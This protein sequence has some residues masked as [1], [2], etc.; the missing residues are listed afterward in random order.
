[1]AEMLYD[2]GSAF[3]NYF[4]IIDLSY[5]MHSLCM[6]TFASKQYALL[7][8]ILI[9][10]FYVCIINYIVLRNNNNAKNK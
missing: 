4:I 6:L 9:L 7:V 2:F 3:M 10:Y 1:M 8:I 5:V